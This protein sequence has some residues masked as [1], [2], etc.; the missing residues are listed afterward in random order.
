MRRAGAWPILALSAQLAAGDAVAAPQQADLLVVGTKEAAPFAIRQPDGTWSGIGIELWREVAEELGLAYRIVERDLPGLFTGLEDGELDVAV[1]ALTVTAERETTVDFTHPFYTSGLG[2]AVP[3]RQ[4]S[5]FLLVVER[6][7]SPAFLQVVGALVLVLF[8]AGALVWLFER[9]RNPE[10]FGGGAGRGLGSAFWWSAVTMTTVGYGDKAPRTA[11]G[12]AVALVWMFTSVIIISGFTA[13]IASTLTVGQLAT[14]VE[15]PEDLP[16]V[17]V[18]AVAAATSET[19]L[20]ERRIDH[21]TFETPLEALRAVESDD[22]QAA[23]HDAPILRYLAR[24][25][26]GGAV[27]VLPRTFERQDYSIAVTEGSVL[28]EPISR[29][30][31][32]VISEAEWQDVLFRYLGS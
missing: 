17:R 13:A 5:D 31:L 4:K 32:R 21:V 8:L 18:A 15:G 9:R 12:R 11:G 19:Y 7:V 1:A 22:V 26:L 24:T 28:R 2:I 10:Q 20:R 25:E 3:A 30:L 6:F 16:G 29:V 27:R 23:V 14:A